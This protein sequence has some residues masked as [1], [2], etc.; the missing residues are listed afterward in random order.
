SQGA[1]VALLLGLLVIHAALNSISSRVTAFTN[2]LSFFWHVFA[3]IAM[4]GALLATAR[5]LNAPSY[6]LTA[7]TPNSSV[8]GI[9]SPPYIF[10]MGLLMAQ[11][12]L[13]GYDASIHVAE[14]TIDAQNAASAALVAS[15]CLCSGLGLGVLLSLTFAMQSMASI[16]SPANATG[17]HSAMTQLFWDVFQSRYGS[18][19]GALG[20]SYIPLVGLFFCANASLAANARMLYAF[21]RDGAMPGFRIWRRL[22]P[23]SRLPLHA[24]WLMAALAGLLGVPCVLNKRFF[25]TVSA[26]SVVALSL[27]YG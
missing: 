7:W 18:G 1:L 11:W 23:S 12:A 21:S 14:E 3:S 17:G 5:S 8:H 24:C 22:H 10:L 9:R 26:G 25:H 13:M 2:T 15:V 27:S 16:L 20:L 19:I 6:V 4:C